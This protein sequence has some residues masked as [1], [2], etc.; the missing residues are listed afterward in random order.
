MNREEC[1]ELLAYVAGFDNRQPSAA[2]L[3]AWSQAL[4]EVPADQ[5]TYRAVADFY[6]QPAP[7]GELSSRWLQP[8]QVASLR[9]QIRG[10]RI[11]PTQPVYEPA[12][13]DESPAQYV[14]NRRRQL[15]GI[16]SGDVPPPEAYALKGGP[17]PSV[18]RAITTGAPP[19]AE[20]GQ[21]LAEAGMGRRF[22][23]WPE[24]Q[25][26]CPVHSCRAMAGRR[27]KRPSGKEIRSATHDSRK[28]EWSSR[29]ASGWPQDP[30]GT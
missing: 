18:L 24:M 15:R 6:G 8:H 2:A 10:A 1:A 16:A 7:R 19:P 13:P 21:Q 23:R 22:A 30:T 26:P 27:C 25:V 20:V 3:E 28:E 4:R 11:G 17:H 14:A 12:D 5:D 9:R 29:G